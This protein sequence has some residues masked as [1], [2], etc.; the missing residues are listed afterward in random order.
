ME[1]E[2]ELAIKQTV[3]DG[4]QGPGILQVSALGFLLL[5][6][7]SAAEFLWEFICCERFKR[8][9]VQE[10]VLLMRMMMMMTTRANLLLTVP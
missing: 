6:C 1:I 7:V 3:T 10:V 9:S 5:V 8:N 4:V 2:Q